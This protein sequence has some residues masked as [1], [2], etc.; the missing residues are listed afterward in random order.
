[1]DLGW[2]T[3]TTLFGNSALRWILFALVALVATVAL[4]SARE[5]GR[6]RLRHMVGR[7]R[8]IVDDLL[9]D[10]V[11]NVWT[12]VLAGLGLW[13]GSQL[14][15]LP[16]GLGGWLDTA[17]TLL[18]ILQGGMWGNR[19]IQVAVRHYRTED[20]VDGARRTTLAALTFLGRL[21]LFSVLILL[22]LDNLGID[23]TALLAGVGI[24]AVAIGLALQNI[25]SDLFASLSI[26]LDKPFEI[27]DFIVVDDLAGT[28]ENVG[29][30]TTRVRSLSGEQLVFANNDLLTSRIRNYKR[31]QERRVVF[32]LGVV[33]DTPHDVLAEI[34]GVV[35][36]IVEQQASVRFDRAHLKGFGPSSLDFEVVYWMLDPDYTAFM[37]TQQ[38]I[39]L[40]LVR[41]FTERGIEFA[42]PTQ[43]LHVHGLQGT[44]RTAGSE[45]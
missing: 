15:E 1:M 3:D 45:G 2:L 16:S 39:N 17:I 8:N 41:A 27:D 38:T 20:G 6:R 25:L 43:T 11:S 28:V 19:S 18:L 34:P 33:Y 12:P 22:A 21:T 35:R 23:I 13:L 26:V 36:D 29:L 24:G 37:D 10:L 30:R 7:T 40:A 14:L 4:R 42:F 5:L 31:M 44:P 32:S 9:S